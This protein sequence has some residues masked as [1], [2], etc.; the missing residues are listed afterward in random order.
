MGQQ[1][2]TI[3]YMPGRHMK[4]EEEEILIVLRVKLSSIQ[5]EYAMIH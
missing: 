4:Q 1:N 2:I 3:Y 5:Y